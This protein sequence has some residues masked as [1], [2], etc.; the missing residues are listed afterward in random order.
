MLLSDFRFK[1]NFTGLSDTE[2][3][4]FLD[5][6]EVAWSGIRSLWGKL[7]EPVRTQKRDLCMN[8][9]SAWYIA[10][11]N[12]RALIGG[13]FS[14]GGTPLNSKSIDGVSVTYK[15]RVV[16]ESMSQ[17]LSN[18]FG[19]KALDMITNAPDMLLIHGY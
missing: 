4:L 14:T 6:A 7:P 12:P 15:D 5:E 9:V 17:F 10:D 18:G 2:L 11:L 13:I 16:Q 8:Y 3:Q 19:L 1:E